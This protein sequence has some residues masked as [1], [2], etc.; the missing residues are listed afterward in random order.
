MSDHIKQHSVGTM[1]FRADSRQI[2]ALLMVTG[3]CAIFQPLGDIAG[4]IGP[5]GTTVDQGIPLSS[6]IGGLC[7]VTLGIGAIFVG[8]NQ[9]VHDHGHKYL[10]GAVMIF[11]QT[12]FIGYI[13]T[14]VDI[15]KRSHKGMGFIP[16]AYNPT[17]SDVRFVGAMG[18]MGVISYGFTFVG[19]IS[20]MAFSLYAYQTGRP[21]D[22]NGTYYKGRLSFYTGM[23]FV[24]GMAQLLLGSYITKNFST[25][26][27]GPLDNGPIGVAMFLVIIPGITVFLGTFQV[28][29]AFWGM[30]RS[31]NVLVFGENDKSYQI[32]MFIMWVCQVVMQA[33]TQT[34]YLPGDAAAVASP[35]IVAI[36]FGLNMMP[37]Y[38][39]YKSR[40]TPAEITP[41]YYD[42]KHEK[43]SKNVVMSDES[44][45][46][47]GEHR[48]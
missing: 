29:N 10:T 14:I 30:A 31:F 36:S 18:I 2:S 26:G 6:L 33:I 7:L 3:F 24:A 9:L 44:E 16:S 35:T 28:V 21:E 15:A 43:S 48:V 11:A 23:L 22:R 8:Y 47:E 25:S 17:Y 4:A 38:L 19:A 1:R 12:A 39:D 34:S 32:S 41:E 20:F 27:G 37:A 40:S 46:A 45:L 5:S 42:S 13:T